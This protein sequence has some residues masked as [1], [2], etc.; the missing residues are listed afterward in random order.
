MP[1]ILQIYSTGKA[2]TIFIQRMRLEK[3]C[4]MIVSID[5]TL[6]LVRQ[7]TLKIII[8]IIIY[9]QISIEVVHSSKL[10]HIIT[11]YSPSTL[12]RPKFVHLEY[13]LKIVENYFYNFFYYIYRIA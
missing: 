3:S 4:E 12:Y 9:I 11:E 5:L 2:K 6:G 7:V 8:I 1:R 13:I 10:S